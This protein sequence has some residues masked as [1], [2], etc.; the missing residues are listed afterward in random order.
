MDKRPGAKLL[1]ESERDAERWLDGK[2]VWVIDWKTLAGW[3]V[4]AGAAWALL[5]V[6]WLVLSW[7]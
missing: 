2:P 5:G 4:L 3:T 1:Q 7:M 6:L